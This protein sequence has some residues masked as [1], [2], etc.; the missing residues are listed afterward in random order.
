MTHSNQRA[1]FM[2]AVSAAVLSAAMTGGAAQAA[3]ANASAAD[4]HGTIA[5]VVV[6]GER[7]EVK[8]QKFPSAVA[9]M[10]SQKLE[11][12]GA[13]NFYDLQAQTPSLNIVETGTANR[14]INIRGVGVSVSTPFQYAGVPLHVDGMYIPNSAAFIRDTYFDVDR[15]E[16]YRGPQG[17]FAGQNSTGGAVFVVTKSPQFDKFGAQI[18]QLVGNYDWFQTQ[19]YVNL[20]INQTMAARIGFNSERRSSFYKN[21]GGA[22]PYGSHQAVSNTPGN[23][24]VMTLRPQLRWRPN[25]RLD[26]RL[27]YLYNLENDDGPAQVR[28]KPNTFND[29]KQLIDPWSLHYDVPQVY[30]STIHRGILNV[31][32]QLTD[33]VQ[34]K[35][36]TGGQYQKTH[37]VL[38]ADSST[39]FL[40]DAY[41]ATTS[42]VAQSFNDFKDVYNYWFQEV[43]LVGNQGPLKWTLGGIAFNEI[44]WLYNHTPTYNRNN[45]ATPA[46][47]LCTTHDV[48]NGGSD[49]DYH[50]SFR[51]Y[52]AF[53]DASYQLLPQLQLT[54]GLRYTTYKVDLVPGSTVRSSVPPNALSAC[55][56]ASPT[57]KTVNPCNVFG[58]GK[59]SRFTGRV[60]V[61]WT[62]TKDINL[63]A[64]FSQ[65][66]KPGAF[67]S[68]FTLQES[69]ETQIANGETQYKSE[70]VRNYEAGIKAVWFDR[71]L[72]TNVSGFYEDYRDY[73][74]NFVIPGTIIPRAF[75][76][77]KSRIAG[78]EAEVEGVFGD[79]RATVTGAYV[80]SRILSDSKVNVTGN[81]LAPG[82][83]SGP[84]PL[85]ANCLATAAAS[86]LTLTYGGVGPT[87]PFYTFDPKGR[88]LNYAPN[89]TLNASL[90]YDIHLPNGVL[91]PRLQY[92]YISQQWVSLFHASQDS[93]P[94]HHTF[95]FRLAYKG[96][97]HW[98]VEGF[99]TNLTNALYVAGVVPAAN[100][101]NA[102]GGA[103]NLGAP[104]QFGMR[105]QYT[106]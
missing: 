39:P 52:A 65:G 92:A 78:A 57:D 49:L 18:Q 102:S 26:V 101:A 90:E 84:P 34:L 8:L 43:D 27:E 66:M 98:R 68:Q 56:T 10:T 35:T 33:E 80:N 15:V 13:Q 21:Y 6:T 75:N 67:F 4:Q 19:G 48:V 93:M 77:P 64:T 91:T 100:A 3:E 40:P 42:Y 2:G 89:W 88:P 5:E 71:R 73:Q 20:P 28:G 72:R 23:V 37:F 55:G 63:Y 41:A 83:P 86:N 82:C 95:D 106:Y 60:A 96:P 22:D 76:I 11:S 9:A 85:S 104:R 87:G 47:P 103:V 30:K 61:D 53:A 1:R 17:T 29:P 12:T 105:V 59:F 94:E 62:P 99:V 81:Y 25:D 44:D 14:F 31:Q 7:R 24:D 79:L 32:Y 16:I 51:S 45:C 46:Q 54:A 74:A 97:E 38:D 58:E 36:V 50:Q 69:H 70:T